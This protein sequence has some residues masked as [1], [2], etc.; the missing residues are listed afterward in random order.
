MNRKKIYISVV[1]HNQENLIIDNFKNLDLKNELFDIKLVFMDNTN[2]V[3]LED[4]AKQNNHLYYADEKTRGYGENHNKNFL[5]A[6]VEDEDIFIVCNPDVILEKEQLLG[7]LSTFVSNN[8]EFGNVTCYYDREKTILSNPDRYFPYF[9]NFVA[10]ILLRKRLHYGTNFDVKFP[11]WISGEFMIIK[12]ET[13]KKLNGFDEEYF[14]YV[15]DIDLCYRANKMGIKITH[16]KNFYIIH[17]TQ[18]DSRNILSNRFKMH[19]NSVFIYLR[20]HKIYCPIKI[21]R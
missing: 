15:E 21:A 8:E 10:S 20:K 11:Q 6:N 12:A 9:F 13:Y 1:S 4:F 3:K 18:M 19:F 14:M 16:N 5:I 2:S 17:E 7:M